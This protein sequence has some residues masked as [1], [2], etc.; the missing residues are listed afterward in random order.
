[1]C[2]SPPTSWWSFLQKSIDTAK[3]RTFFLPLTISKYLFYHSTLSPSTIHRLA[4]SKLISILFQPLYSI[5]SDVIIVDKPREK[6]FIC[7]HIFI[8]RATYFEDK[9][10]TLNIMCFRVYKYIQ[11]IRAHVNDH[12]SFLYLSQPSRHIPS[13]II[14][15]I[16]QI[17]NVTTSSI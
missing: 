4:S 10:Y 1:M 9:F 6:E 14:Q 7:Q 15:L 5:P 12:N 8:A 2:M 11:S 16:V 3:T 13:S 17:F